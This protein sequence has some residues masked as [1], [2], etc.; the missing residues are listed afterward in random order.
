MTLPIL[1]VLLVFCDTPGVGIKE[2]QKLQSPPESLGVFLQRP[3]DV[4][5]NKDGE[6]FVLDA[7]AQTIWHWDAQGHFV[8]KIGNKGQGPGEFSFSKGLKTHRP[9]VAV[10][11]E[12]LWVF[13]DGPHRISVFDQQGAFTRSFPVELDVGHPNAAAI[14][15]AEQIMVL[16]RTGNGKP[17]TYVLVQLNTKGSQQTIGEFEIPKQ[18]SRTDHFLLGF[19]LTMVHWYDHSRNLLLTGTG[20]KPHFQV[21][22]QGKPQAKIAV[23][24]VE[25]EVTEGDKQEFREYESANYDHS[26]PLEFP[27][28]KPLYN[29]LMTVGQTD[30][31]VASVSPFYKR[32]NGFWLGGDGSVKGRIAM[33]LGSDGALLGSNGDLLAVRVDEE[34]AFN[35]SRIHL[36]P[37]P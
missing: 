7:G 15:S 18:S 8:S 9:S 19:G 35:L 31:L 12:E 22:S 36:K 25:I 1:A 11:G 4:A 32:L 28:K 17:E 13:D 20:E 24:G 23:P 6:T 10:V 37:S 21:W 34:G 29:T 3:L 27:E 5:W 16:G 14:G 26:H 33:D 2:G 30:Y